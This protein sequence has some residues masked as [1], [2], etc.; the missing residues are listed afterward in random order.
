MCKIFLGTGDCELNKNCKSDI[1]LVD[2][3]AS[4]LV[5]EIL[6][7]ALEIVD[8]VEV[9]T[10]KLGGDIMETLSSKFQEMNLTES[11]NSP[12]DIVCE[13]SL[14]GLGDQLKAEEGA[15]SEEPI[16]H[17][18]VEK[19]N[20]LTD[21]VKNSKQILSKLILSE[22]TH[23]IEVKNE[24]VI[25]VVDLDSKEQRY[26]TKVAVKP[27]NVPLPPCESSEILQTLDEGN[28]DRPEGEKLEEVEL[29]STSFKSDIEEIRA[30]TMT[31]PLAGPSAPSS[32][33]LDRYRTLKFSHD[34][35]HKKWNIG[36]KII[37]YIKKK[38]QNRKSDGK[39]SKA[40][41]GVEITPKEDDNI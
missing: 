1:K 19:K 14:K 36:S 37:N 21:L 18:P 16:K 34:F 31:F 15:L 26:K 22:S 28:A 38:G 3:L 6:E 17:P 29:A 35:K 7:N 11:L 12:D 32:S 33:F 23:N 20:R 30:K 39:E 24:K 2:N 8:D 5:V 41:N 13:R 25:R 40:S 4:D 27:E 10:C 9:K